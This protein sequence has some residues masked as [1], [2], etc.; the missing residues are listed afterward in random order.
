MGL[1]KIDV[2]RLG[3]SGVVGLG[4]I[5]LASR[6]APKINPQI[7]AAAGGFLAGGPLG[8]AA[9][10]FAPSLLGLKGSDTGSGSGW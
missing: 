9:G 5:V 7:A 4:T 8:A 3:L 6:F 2:K 10:Y 1:G